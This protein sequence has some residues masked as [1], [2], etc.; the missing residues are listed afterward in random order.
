MGQA[1][2]TF[3]NMNT[4]NIQHQPIAR[5]ESL[6]H[7]VQH[8]PNINIQKISVVRNSINLRRRSLRLIHHKD[9]KYLINFVFDS[10]CDVEI[11][12]SFCC[13]EKIDEQHQSIYVSTKYETFGKVFPSNVNCTY[14]SDPEAAIDFN[15]MDINDL[16]WKPQYENIVPVLITLKALGTEIP[17]I[18]FTLAYIQEND[19]KGKFEN[20][21]NDRYKLI[22]YGQKI[23]L[24]SRI[25]EMK[26]I[27]GIEKLK[28]LEVDPVNNFLSGRE[29]VICLSAERN[30][31]VLPCRHM[32]L[33][34]MCTHIVRLH[35][36]KCPICRQNVIGFLQMSVDEREK[37]GKFQGASSF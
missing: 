30:T 24:G 36:T 29:C 12:I 11:T 27:Y 1:V 18:Q 23:Q 26:E 6:P 31:V 20:I 33:C 15:R 25:F 10:L 22:I 14:L 7:L 3:M 9:N 21:Q 2:A 4:V 35:N 8:E 37:R 28:E 32:C 17:Q 16:K 19:V 13:V 5:A 34:N